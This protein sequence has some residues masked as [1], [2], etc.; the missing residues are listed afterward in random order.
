MTMK[1][2][3]HQVKKAVE[4]VSSNLKKK[5]EADS[6]VLPSME[7]PIPL[8]EEALKL[9]ATFFEKGFAPK[10]IFNITS[11]QM[12]GMYAKAYNLYQSGK[13]KEAIQ[14]FRLLIMLTPNESKYSLG[15]AACFHMMKDYDNAIETYTMYSVLN[16]DDPIGYFHISDCLL[17]TNEK[18]SAI[19]ALEMAIEKANSPQFKILKDR[20]V[21]TV[22]NLKKELESELKQ[23][24]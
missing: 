17:S 21:L 24:K 8:D 20:A 11:G 10:D 15:L 6:D 2:D 22:E 12:E 13:Y 23:D 16:P 4:T 5:T 14:I 7:T 18:M 3:K 1:S 19:V 9:G